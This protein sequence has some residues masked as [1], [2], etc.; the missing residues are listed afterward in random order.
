MQTY[1]PDGT[2]KSADPKC[3]NC[4]QVDESHFLDKN[5]MDFLSTHTKLKNAKEFMRRINA[6]KAPVLGVRSF[7]HPE[8]G[9]V[10]H[11]TVAVPNLDPNSE[12]TDI[13]IWDEPM[14]ERREQNCPSR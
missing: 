1:Y 12:I 2:I 9:P 5:W 7:H 8:H 13:T 10:L 6:A 14:D 11:R 4:W 3:C